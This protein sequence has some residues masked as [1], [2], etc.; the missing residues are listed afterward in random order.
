[1]CQNH[2]CHCNSCATESHGKFKYWNEIA[3]AVLLIVGMILG[4]TLSPWLRFLFFIAAIAP[5]AIPILKELWESWRE[6]S[7]MNEFTLMTAAAVGAFAIGEYPEAVAILLFYSLGEKL[8]SSASDDVRK[9]IKSLIGKLPDTARIINADGTHTELSPSEIGVGSRILIKPGERVPIDSTF[10]GDRDAAFDTSA[11]TGES[12]PRTYSPGMEIPSG[13]IPIDQAIEATTLRPFSDSSM[14]RI[15]AMVESA[16]ETKSKSETLL[17][18]ITRWYTPVVFIC[19]LLLFIIPLG[20]SLIGGNSFNW[21]E[22]LNRSL[23]FLVCSCPCALVV[24][25]PLSYF[26]SL[27]SA[28]RLGLLFKGSKYVDAMRNVDTVIFDKTGTLTTGEFSVSEIVACNGH[29]NDEVLGIAAAIDINSSH[30]LAKAIVAA[31]ENL[32]IALKVAKDVETVAHGITGIIDGQ[33]VAVGSRVLMSSLGIA[34]TPTSG[35]GS[36]IVVAVDGQMIGSI[37]LIDNVKS[38]AK[39]AIAD[40]HALGVKNVV[41]LSGDRP[42]AVERVASLVNADQF[43]GALLPSDKQCEVEKLVQQGERV[44]FV[45]DGINDSPAIATATVGIAMG[46]MGSDIAMESADIVVVGD[47]LSKLPI[48]I[49]LA[50]RLHN[51]VL[52][53]V[54]FAI[55]V[56]LLIMILGAFGIASLWAAVFADTGVTLL[57]ILWTLIR[58]RSMPK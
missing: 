42:E 49:R 16:Q 7:F 52:Q 47:K 5:V 35:T 30:P 57:T 33:K 53:N 38:E 45:G 27:G 44:A 15:L 3:T 25:I 1:M 24:S 4:D 31:A 8:E 14:S 17:R 2:S 46:T 12:V 11:I 58:L 26:A 36:E 29:T 37:F 32:G 23:V 43:K 10:D 13:I 41:I 19:A 22:W 18:R 28:S 55:G 51:V 21:S 54:S 9:R 40:L 50:R 20:I 39:S 56:K 34:T 48:S 6:R